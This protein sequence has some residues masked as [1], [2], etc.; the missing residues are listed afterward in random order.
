MIEFLGDAV[1]VG[2]NV[3]FDMAFINSA[4]DSPWRSRDHQPGH[5][6]PAACPAADPRRGARLSPRNLGFAIPSRPPAL[7]PSTRRC[8]RNDRPVALPARARC[9][10][11]RA[12]ARRPDRAA[13][14][15][16]PPAGRKAAN[17]CTDCRAA[18]ACTCSAARNDQVLYVGKAT[19]LRQRVRSYFG[20]DDRRKI[21]TLLREAQRISHVTTPNVLA[22]EVL[23][24]R[25]IQQLD[26]RYNKVGTAPQKYRYVR[27]TTDEAW[28]RLSV[29]N[30]A[31]GAG[32][33]LG[34]LPSKASADA[35]VEALQSVFPLRRCTTRL[36]RSFQPQTGGDHLHP[37]AT[38]CGHVPVRRRT[39]MPMH[40]AAVV[41]NAVQA[42]TTSPELV[43]AAPAGSARDALSRTSVRRGRAGPRPSDGLLQRDAPPATDRSTPRGRRRRRCRSATPM[44][45][46][47][48]G[49][50]VGTALDGQMEIGLPL[51]PPDVPT[52]AAAAPPPCRRRGAVPGPR[53]RTNRPHR[54]TV[55]WCDGR[56][57]WPID[58]VPEV[59]GRTPQP[60][61]D[62][63]WPH[64]PRSVVGFDHGA[65]VI[66]AQHLGVAVSR[67][68]ARRAR[69]R[70]RTGT[71]PPPSGPDPDSHEHHAPA[72]SAACSA[73]VD[74]STEASRTILVKPILRGAAQRVGV[75]G[76]QRGDQQRR[77]ADVEHG[78]AQRHLAAHLGARLVGRRRER[79]D[80]HD[81]RR[82]ERQWDPH[83]RARRRWRRCR[84]TATRRRCRRGLRARWPAPASP[85]T[86]SASCSGSL[87]CRWA[88][89]A[90]MPAMRT[91]PLNPR[92]RPTG[93]GEHTHRS[94]SPP[95][96]RKATPAGWNWSIRCAPAGTSPSITPA[97]ACN[98]N[99]M[100]SVSKPGP[101]FADDA[102]TRT[103]T[104]GQTADRL[105]RLGIRGSTDRGCEPRGLRRS[106]TWR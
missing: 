85:G 75:A 65:A 32:V 16:R 78:V 45:H 27:L 80:P 52:F 56:W 23:E 50:L 14:H 93:M 22:A 60:Q 34:P 79:R 41:A 70:R 89:A 61:L 97:S 73:A 76:G 59:V 84:R 8:A 37:G 10:A 25:Y 47:R 106:T 57:Q 99:A 33:H 15:R 1:V 53:V 67:H 102:G 69:R 90:T 83:R 19:N 86:S 77:A 71:S 94:P 3:G 7:A 13:S 101:R 18:P 87:P 100:P 30:E 58:A 96:R 91:A 63:E 4:L 17:D 81:D 36:G 6:H 26:P 68:A 43:I 105:R 42:M 74:G 88:W 54:V 12:R 98:D 28:P 103:I 62:D 39:P 51:P 55:L 104:I 95:A 31:T 21:G 11:R 92:P 49:V 64:Q 2:H 48:H 5:R 29:V 20:S 66:D 24:L 46:V 40:Y 44:L 9:R 72:S 38:R 82:V 35:V